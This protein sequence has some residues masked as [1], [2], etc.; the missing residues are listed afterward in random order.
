MSRIIVSAFGGSPLV[1]ISFWAAGLVIVP[2]TAYAEDQATNETIEEVVV[3][4]T[5]RQ[6]R[7][8]AE[9]LSPI[10]VISAEEID[11]QGFSEMDDLL[12]TNVPSYQ[13]NS[14]LIDDAGTLVRPAKLRGLAPDQTLIL[15]NGQRRHRSAVINF[16]SDGLTQGVQG[17]DLSVIPAGA[18]DR[19]EV[20]RVGAAAQYGSDA[21]AGVI[22]FILK[23][24]A[25]GGRV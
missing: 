9:S 13:V 12:R 11:R 3:T 17:P 22:N 7:T 8:V 10:D 15:V 23:E 24:G 25:S 1:A 4:G 21:I 16:I 14:H 5:R 2:A 20:L 19:V 6:D 18:L